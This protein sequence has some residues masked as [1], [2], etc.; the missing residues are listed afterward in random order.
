MLTDWVPSAHY[1]SFDI[2]LYRFSEFVASA[3]WIACVLLAKAHPLHFY[4]S[5]SRLCVCGIPRW[6]CYRLASCNR[7]WH[8]NWISRFV[9][10]FLR[11]SAKH[12]LSCSLVQGPRG[13]L[14]FHTRKCSN[15]TTANPIWRSRCVIF[16]FHACR[17]CFSPYR[18]FFRWHTDWNPD[19][20]LGGWT[21]Y[22]CSTRSPCKNT[23]FTSIWCRCHPFAAATANK[24][25]TVVIFMIGVKVSS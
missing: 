8:Y 1:S 15:M 21:I 25:W 9:C 6:V 5:V 3:L 12:S 13:P 4:V 18:D 23:Y 20:N 16:M 7:Y 19:W 2:I 22:T 11:V 17:A 10:L 14:S 24:T